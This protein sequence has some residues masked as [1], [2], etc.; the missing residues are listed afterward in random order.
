MDGGR[1]FGSAVA[2]SALV[3]ALVIGAREVYKKTLESV[4]PK[5]EKGASVTDGKEVGDEEG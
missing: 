4:G 1:M 5:P 3:P 2:L